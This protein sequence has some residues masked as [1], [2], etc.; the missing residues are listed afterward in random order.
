MVLL[1]CAD[2]QQ[3]KCLWES[4]IIESGLCCCCYF[5]TFY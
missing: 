3:I 2:N 4:E 1:Y 5:W